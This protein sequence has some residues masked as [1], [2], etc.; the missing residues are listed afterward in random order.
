MTNL[1]SKDKIRQFEKRSEVVKAMAHATRLIIIDELSKKDLCVCEIN[2]F[3]TIDQSTL[4]KHLAILKN[5]GIIESQKKGQKVYYNLK[6][7]CITNYLGCVE[8]VLNER[9]Q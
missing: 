3:F 9:F 5:A 2:E 7:P 4:S 1:I 6:T 8:R